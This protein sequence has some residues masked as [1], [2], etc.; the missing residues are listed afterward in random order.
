MCAE[1]PAQQIA[2]IDI[3]SFYAS[4]AAL[5]EGLDVMRD[6]IAVVGNL[7]QK[8]SIVLAASP[9]MKKRFNVKTGTRLYEIPKHP[10]IYLIEPKMATYLELSMEIPKV[11]N[12]Y[13]PIEAIHV[14][15]VDE[16]FFD[17][18]G[19]ERL[20]GPVRQTIEQIQ[21]DLLDQFQLPSAV[22]VGPNMLM[23]KLALDLDAKKSGYA[24]WT[25]DDVETKLWSVSPLSAMWGIGRRT[26]KTLNEMGIFSVGDLANTELTRLEKK[27]GIVGN[28]LYY[29]AWGIDLSKMGARYQEEPASYGKGQTLM[30][31]YVTRESVLVVILEMCEDICGRARN[32]RKNART[33][34]LSIGYSKHSS[35]GGF[36][37]S[38]TIEEPSNDTLKIYR[39]CVV[40]FDK[41]H[42]GRSVRKID[43]S[44]TN[45][46]DET[47]MQLDL[48]AEDK[49]KKRKL[50][51]AMDDIRNRY[52]T[53]AIIRGVS[54]TKDG[55]AIKRS[56]LV[57]GH[58]E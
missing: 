31:D 16:C 22:G 55:T 56:R 6:A 28:Q 7:Q 24:R 14:Y 49:W 12:K 38:F 2:C 52:G 21:Y 48:F 40:L 11:L 51:A 5:L 23:A 32:A 34:H 35:S 39:T 36:S 26:E 10:D 44:I 50:A 27:F 25:Y 47:S 58:K 33:I 15:S 54:L 13:V 19:T 8:G 20:W 57:G 37:R 4:C 41:F 18:T 53:T 9:P 17:L 42:D 3:R 29:H 30:R 1:L 46:E 45:L 43:I